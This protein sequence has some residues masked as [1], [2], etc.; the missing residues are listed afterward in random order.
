MFSLIVFFLLVA[1]CLAA[2]QPGYQSFI[3]EQNGSSYFTP[4][5]FNTS[6]YEFASTVGP[7]PDSLAKRSASVSAY[8]PCTVITLNA[9]TLLTGSY[10]NAVVT[11]YGTMDDVWSTDFLEA[12][13]IQYDGL[14]TGVELD[15]NVAQFFTSKGV[16]YAFVSTAFQH[17]NFTM[18]TQY[19]PTVSACDLTN[20]PYIASF[21]ACG[22]GLS[23]TP[24][25][26]LHVDAYE[27]ML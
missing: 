4:L 10:L 18:T 5:A 21:S 1:Q 12:V 2:I 24:A 11:K 14:E 23:M 3:W 16:K 17:P 22:T 15:A 13:F 7:V 8:L 9:S 19:F 26:K 20:G 6:A 25:Y 27:G